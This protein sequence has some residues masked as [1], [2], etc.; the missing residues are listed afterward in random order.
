MKHATTLTVDDIEAGY[1]NDD[2]QG[3]GYL[4]ERMRAGSTDHRRRTAADTAVLEVANANGWSAQRLFEDFLNAKVGRWF[5][6]IAYGSDD[7]L[8]RAATSL[9]LG[10][11]GSA[12]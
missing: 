6:D 10:S 3:F 1:R 11:K 9:M 2:W 5:G 4:G 12:R 8:A 7:D